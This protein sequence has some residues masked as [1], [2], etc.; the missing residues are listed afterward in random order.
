M[1]EWITRERKNLTQLAQ[2]VL[3][4]ANL[5]VGL[6]TLALIVGFY[7]AAEAM[8]I[9]FG[10]VVSVLLF[11]MLLGPPLYTLLV[12]S[13]R[14]PLWRRAV[15]GRI[16]RLRA[17]GFLTSYVDTLGE[18]TLA[19]LPDEPRQTLDRAL[20]QEREGRLPPT[21]LYADALFIA[22]AVDAETSARLP[23]RQRQGDHS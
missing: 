4:K 9:P 18:Q 21:H 13:V 2:R 3:L 17:I 16:R 22:L 23:R 15:A 1:D 10:I 8:E 5:L 12:H 19:R 20:E 6:T 14:G 11:L 7:L